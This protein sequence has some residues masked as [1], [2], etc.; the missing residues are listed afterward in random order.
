MS[1]AI[2]IK[3]LYAYY[4]SIE[5]DFNSLR[6]AITD[7]IRFATQPQKTGQF[8]FDGFEWYNDQNLLLF[9]DHGTPN[10]ELK[11]GEDDWVE[12]IRRSG[13]PFNTGAAVD[14]ENLNH[15]MTLIVRKM[16]ELSTF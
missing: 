13:E 10:F 6:S 15:S 12:I 3:M 16:Q 7:A 2:P 9:G 4:M 1:V 11:F 8:C 14:Y 5:P